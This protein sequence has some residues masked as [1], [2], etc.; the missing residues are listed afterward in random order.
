MLLT[1]HFVQCTR[2]N[3]PL[4]DIFS[5][6]PSLPICR[7][8]LAIAKRIAELLT[9]GAELLAPG[10]APPAKFFRRPPAPRMAS[11]RVR[12]VRTPQAP[13]GGPDGACWASLHRRLRVR[14]GRRAGR[15]F[16]LGRMQRPARD[17][18]PAIRIQPSIRRCG[19]A[20][21]DRRARDAKPASTASHAPGTA[22]DAR[23]PRPPPPAG[24]SRPDADQGR[25]GTEWRA[26]RAGNLIRCG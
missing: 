7:S 26:A 20:A 23:R 15:A 10:P 6:P 3:I 18:A 2:A 13:A 22:P 12:N 5:T 24:Q 8:V 19:I 14:I 9:V 25:R 11:L 16:V 17:P 1:E 4:V 21:Q